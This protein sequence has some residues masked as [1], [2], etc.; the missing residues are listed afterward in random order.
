MNP[1]GLKFPL[2]NLKLKK[3]SNTLSNSIIRILGMLIL[4]LTAVQLPDKIKTFHTQK[5]NNQNRIYS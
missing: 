3:K 2:K 5:M 1:N 4:K